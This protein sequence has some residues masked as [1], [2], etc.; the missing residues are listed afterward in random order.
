MGPDKHEGFGGD[1]TKA[2]Q[3]HVVS[4]LLNGTPLENEARDYLRVIEIESAI[5]RS[6]EE[7]RKLAV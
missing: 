1:C 6:A 3:G 2:L 4:A 5:Y 7:G